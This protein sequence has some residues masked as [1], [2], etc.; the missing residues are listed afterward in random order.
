VHIRN[1]V[2]STVGN[3]Y[4]YRYHKSNHDI[5]AYWSRASSVQ[6]TVELYGAGRVRIKRFQNDNILKTSGTGLY[7]VRSSS[8]MKF[9]QTY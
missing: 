3:T 5:Y 7:N 8:F 1:L 6:A 2:S 4:L 9:L